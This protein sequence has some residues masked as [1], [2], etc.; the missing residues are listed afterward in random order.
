[1]REQ[2]L[3][4]DK[5]IFNVEVISMSLKEI[6]KMKEHAEQV[7]NFLQCLELTEIPKCIHYWYDEDACEEDCTLTSLQIIRHNN[8]TDFDSKIECWECRNRKERK[9]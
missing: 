5:R 2:L 3:D 8:N 9:K 7:L 1:V 6:H 4:V